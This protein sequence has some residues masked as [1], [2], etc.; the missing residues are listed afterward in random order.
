[1]EGVWRGSG[2]GFS[3]PGG[4]QGVHDRKTRSVLERH[5][6]DVERRMDR[7][8]RMTAEAVPRL[9]ALV[10]VLTDEAL[11]GE[12][13]GVYWAVLQA[14]NR[15]RD[16]RMRSVRLTRV[17]KRESALTASR[18]GQRV[19]ARSGRASVQH[20]KTDGGLDSYD[21]DRRTLGVVQRA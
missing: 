21:A 15:L 3:S 4:P 17:T 9:Q 10:D 8:G 2:G 11:V 16:P 18:A 12:A 20:A 7:S 14:R 6:K 13:E 1:M 5:V 19:D